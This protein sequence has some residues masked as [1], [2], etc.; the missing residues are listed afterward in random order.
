PGGAIWA[1]DGNQ[2][3]DLLGTPGPGSISQ[4]L[5]TTPGMTY[6]L[7][8]A[9][10]TNP[11]VLTHVVTNGV[12]VYWNG[13]LIDTITTPTAK[14]WVVRNYNVTASSSS[15]TLEF[16]S[17][18]ASDQGPLLDAV[19]VTQKGVLLNGVMAGDNVSLD[20]TGATGTFATKD[21]GSAKTVA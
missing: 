21:V 9:L 10:S 19:S 4:N 14:T 8:F 2:S 20:T 7:S 16:L 1:Y 11:S 18:I 15:T 6:T 13:M 17:P 3:V 12:L 5:A